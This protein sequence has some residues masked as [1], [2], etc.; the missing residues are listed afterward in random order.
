MNKATKNQSE[1]TL[2]NEA[3]LDLAA[4]LHRL[5]LGLKRDLQ[6]NAV[7]PGLSDLAAMRPL[8]A[9]LTE[10]LTARVGEGKQDDDVVNSEHK[11]EYEIPGYL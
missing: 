3:L 1:R 6:R 7:L 11:A 5:V 10:A 2:N 9:I 8:H 4:E